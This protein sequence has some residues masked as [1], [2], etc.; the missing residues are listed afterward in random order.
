MP[1]RRHVTVAFAA[2]AIAFAMCVWMYEPRSDRVIIGADIALVALIIAYRFIEEAP[3][4]TPEEA[5]P[6]SAPEPTPPEPA[7]EAV[8]MLAPPHATGG[9]TTESNMAGCQ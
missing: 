1:R 5:Q 8:P 9:N 7:P 3:F 2:V 4:V 6:P